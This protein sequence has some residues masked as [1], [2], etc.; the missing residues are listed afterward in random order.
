M[1]CAPWS[2]QCADCKCIVASYKLEHLSETKSPWIL[3]RYSPKALVTQ[4][5]LNLPDLLLCLS[6]QDQDADKVS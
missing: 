6:V 4:L 1:H 2:V 5:L 3:P